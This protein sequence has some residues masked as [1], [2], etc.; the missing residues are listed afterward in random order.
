MVGP[1][2][3]EPETDTPDQWQQALAE[4]MAAG[5]QELVRWWEQLNDPQ[6][7]ALITR[8]KEGNPGLKETIARIREARAV[9]AIAAG[10]RVPDVNAGGRVARSRLPETFIPPTTDLNR[11]NSFYEIG[12]SATWELDFWGRIRR[13][14][15]SADAS[16][17]GSIE[18][19]RDALVLLYAE[20]ALTYTEVRALQARI[21]Y[22]EGN[23][24]TQEG[25]LQLVVDRNKA[26]I[27]SDLEVRQ[28][29]LNLYRTKATLPTVQAALTASINRLGVLLGESPQALH[30]SLATPQ[31]IPAVPQQILVGV[32]GELIRRRP[33]IRAA[34][35]SLAAE[36]ARI[37]VATA[38]LYPRFG[39]SGDFSM[40]A[41]DAGDITDWGNRRFNI[42]G[43]FSWNIFD[44]GRVRGQ[45]GVQDARTEQALYRY[46]QTV[47][48]ALEEVETNLANFA[49]ERER[50]V[51]LEQS[52]TAAE[53]SVELVLILYRTGLTDFQNVLDMQRSLFEQQDLLA[54]SDGEVIKDLIRIYTSLGGGW[55]PDDLP[56]IN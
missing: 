39:I 48:R 37:G 15:E 46:E 53:K 44:G 35:R 28:A 43:F 22:T 54:A 2:Y 3:V 9:R 6:L 40:L 5:Q 55:D 41:T 32:P 26:G 51:A 33:D 52:A 7:T 31:P 42:G 14:V 49:R 47:L 18:S 24:I 36:T 38:E 11:Y 29:E 16:L 50:R 13:A 17:Q 21:T 1:H 34:E 4:D 27:A 20:V 10:E 8:A 30:T 19:Y 12:A 56:A 23:I 45:I 25:A